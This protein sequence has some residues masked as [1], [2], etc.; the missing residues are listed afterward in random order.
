[1]KRSS[2][3]QRQQTRRFFT[4]SLFA[5]SVLATG[6][7][8]A[9]LDGKTLQGAAC[10]P[11]TQDQ[12]YSTDG[13]GRIF[14]PSTTQVLGVNCP[15]VRDVIAGRSNGIDQAFIKVF[16]NNPDTGREVTC[17]LLS[18]RGDT[19][20]L[21]EAISR[22]TVGSNP[23]VQQL[24]LFTDLASTNGGYYNLQCVIPP[25]TSSTAPMSGVVMYEIDEQD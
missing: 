12:V 18:F 9:A 21:V 20:Q 25:R 23:N 16:D 7:S 24:P 14:N 5:L 22:N 10:Q 1:M 4:G 8:A 19:G 6:G 2:F 17:T 13:A 11:T 15:V 3:T